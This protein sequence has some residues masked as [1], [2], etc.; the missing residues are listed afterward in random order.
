MG[1]VY[2]A[3]VITQVHDNR[4]VVR[5]VAFYRTVKKHPAVSVGKMVFAL[6][7]EDP[8]PVKLL[9]AFPHP[10]P[11]RAMNVYLVP[12]SGYRVVV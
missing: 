7:A 9:W 3:R 8:I 10:T 4:S 6:F 1:W 11:V 12:K 5:P 2:A